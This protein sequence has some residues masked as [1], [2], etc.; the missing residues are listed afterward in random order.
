MQA[1]ASPARGESKDLSMQTLARWSDPADHHSLL[2]T[3]G[4]ELLYGFFYMY[5]KYYLHSILIKKYLLKL[6]DFI[7]N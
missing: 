3:T 7:L 4:I 1:S 6:V 2:K 5:I